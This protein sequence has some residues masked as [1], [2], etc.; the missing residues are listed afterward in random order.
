MRTVDEPSAAASLHHYICHD[1]SHHCYVFSPN[2]TLF[3]IMCFNEVPS[4]P[5]PLPERCAA[6]LTLSLGFIGRRGGLGG[7]GV[8]RD[9]RRDPGVRQIVCAP[10]F[11]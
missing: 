6:L 9:S 10:L 2:N 8:R 5:F 4:P 3:L 7:E 11:G 1:T